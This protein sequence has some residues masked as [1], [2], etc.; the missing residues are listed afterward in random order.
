MGEMRYKGTSEWGN[1]I[2]GYMWER[3]DEIQ[4]CMSMG[5]IRYNSN[6]TCR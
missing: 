2:Q 4:G 5:E 6:C 1:E 3:G